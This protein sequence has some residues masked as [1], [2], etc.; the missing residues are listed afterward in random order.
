MGG[1]RLVVVDV[2]T[3]RGRGEPDALAGAVVASFGRGRSEATRDR[4]EMQ[5]ERVGVVACDVQRVGVDERGDEGLCL[6]DHLAE[7]GYLD[8]A[9]DDPAVLLRHLDRIAARFRRRMT[10]PRRYSTAKA[11]WLAMGAEAIGPEDEEAARVWI[12]HFNTR[13]AAERAALLRLSPSAVPTIAVGRSGSTSPRR[14]GA[15]RPSLPTASIAAPVITTTAG[16][17]IK[18]DLS[19]AWSPPCRSDPSGLTGSPN[20]YPSRSH[21]QADRS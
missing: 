16:S 2:D 13:P 8:P 6:F 20:A 10:D 7:A 4:L 18:R 3:G 5:A 21:L 12:K 1:N 11:M 19:L 17:A 14:A 9:G 15:R